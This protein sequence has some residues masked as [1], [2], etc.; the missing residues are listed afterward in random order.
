MK[1]LQAS[2]GNVKPLQ[3]KCKDI[4]AWTLRDLNDSL[5]QTASLR[6]VMEPTSVTASHRICSMVHHD[7]DFNITGSNVLVIFCLTLSAVT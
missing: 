1:D 4:R 6:I 2:G 5:F 7:E 3:W